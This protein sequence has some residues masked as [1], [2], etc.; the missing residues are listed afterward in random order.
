MDT[1]LIWYPSYIVVSGGI[2]NLNVQPQNVPSEFVV[3]GGT[4]RIHCLFFTIPTLTLSGG[5]FSSNVDIPVRIFNW[6]RHY[7]FLWFLFLELDVSSL[8][9]DWRFCRGTGFPHCAEEH[10]RLRCRQQGP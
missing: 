6:V 4:I 10:Y 1:D 3:T 7:A 9:A 2:A 5:A 8:L